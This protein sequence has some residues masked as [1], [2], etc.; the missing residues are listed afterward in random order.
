MDIMTP[1]LLDLARERGSAFVAVMT[2]GEL[3]EFPWDSTDARWEDILDAVAEIY[4]PITYVGVVT[5][6]V[7]IDSQTY[8]MSEHLTMVVVH[9]AGYTAY[10]VPLKPFNELRDSDPVTS[11]DPTVEE[12]EFDYE[13]LT[14]ILPW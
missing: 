2:E 12:L 10:K 3:V 1:E 5:E 4:E 6:G 14:A 7:T 13:A 9:P 11:I 8:D